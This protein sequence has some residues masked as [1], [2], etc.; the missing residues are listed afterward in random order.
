MYTKNGKEKEKYLEENNMNRR[1]KQVAA[2]MLA[3]A[4]AATMI[5][6]QAGAEEGEKVKIKIAW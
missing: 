6:V 5:P 1:V 4:M 2:V 3:G